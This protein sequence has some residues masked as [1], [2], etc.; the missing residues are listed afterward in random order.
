M[1]HEKITSRDNPR[2]KMVR[3]VRDGKQD[4]RLFVEGLRLC[5]ETLRSPLKIIECYFRGDFVSTERGATLVNQVATR[6]AE[7]FEIGNNGFDS[8]AETPSPQGIILICERPAASPN[9]IDESLGTTESIPVVLF[10]HEIS[11][12]SNLGAIVRTCEAAGASG[13]IIS[14]SSADVFS[15]KALRASMGSAFRLPVWADVSLPEALDWAKLNEMVISA[16]DLRAEHSYTSIDWTRPRL[17]VFGSEAHGLGQAHLSCIEESIQIPMRNNVES[18][19]IAVS[20]G[21]LLFEAKRQ[22]E[23]AD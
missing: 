15:P 5:E 20:C 17:L 18:L 12:P 14:R 13:L 21:I 16:A 10:L 4:D 6:G 3:K 19:N 1:N 8:I 23:A 2:L 22:I 11:N 7:I 9:R